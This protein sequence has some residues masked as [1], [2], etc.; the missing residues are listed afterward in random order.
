MRVMEPKEL[1][2]AVSHHVSGLG[3]EPRSSGRAVSALNCWAIS[4]VQKYFL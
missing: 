3:I 1:Q 2:T 4:L